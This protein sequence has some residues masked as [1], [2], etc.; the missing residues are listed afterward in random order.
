[1]FSN[2]RD[3]MHTPIPFENKN[4]TDEQTLPFKE[5]D[6]AIHVEILSFSNEN[7]KELYEAYVVILANVTRP[8]SIHEPNPA[9]ICRHTNYSNS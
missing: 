6:F 1:M 5:L 9:V 7:R 2:R 3:K 8:I 4:Q